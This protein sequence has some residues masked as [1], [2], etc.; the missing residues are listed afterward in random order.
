MP[1]KE[2]QICTG[3]CDLKTRD[4]RQREGAVMQ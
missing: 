2:N 4:E 3:Q 1:Q